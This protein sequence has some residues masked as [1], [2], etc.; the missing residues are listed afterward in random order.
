MA[1][2][3]RERPARPITA[4]PAHSDAR[5]PAARRPRRTGRHRLLPDV[6]RPAPD[7]GAAPEDVRRPSSPST[8]RRWCPQAVPQEG[9]LNGARHPAR[10]DGGAAPLSLA[11]ARTRRRRCSAPSTLPFEPDA[12]HPRARRRPGG[13]L[14]HR[15]LRG[16]LA[17]RS[18]AA[19]WPARPAR[20]EFL[21]TGLRALRRRAQRPQ[22][23]RRHQPAL[24]LAPL[25]PPLDARG[26]PRR[27]RGAG[28]AEQYDKF[29]DETL[30][31]REVSHN[32]CYFNPRHRTA[33]RHPGVGAGAT[34]ATTRATRGRRSTRTTTS[35]TPAP[36]TNSGTPP[37]AP[38]CATAGCTTTCGCSGAR[39]CCSGRR[40]PPSACGCSSTSTTST[41]ST[42]AT[43][44][45]T[46]ASCG[47][48]GK[49]DRPFYRRPIYGTVR[50][51]SLRAAEDKF[52][53]P[54]YVGTFPPTEPSPRS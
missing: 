21:R 45:A 39:P 47:R 7:H 44:T 40:M 24:A 38:T 29:L 16:A 52:D 50:Y 14:R 23:A 12:A 28:P 26:A 13:P 8:P 20:S 6:H 5:W 9:A 30:T 48:F 19:P 22:R 43:R 54:R 49:F 37:S 32:F 17:R 25:R 27:A 18:V 42:A 34:R 33:G 3:D 15:P 11:G 41:H 51:Q 46:A 2:E 31:W 1:S 36:T 35:S 53:V 4:D 10:A